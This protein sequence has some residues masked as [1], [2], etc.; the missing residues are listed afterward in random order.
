MGLEIEEVPLRASVSPVRP[1]LEALRGSVESI[2]CCK[3]YECR[4]TFGFL[5]EI[6]GL[7]AILSSVRGHHVRTNE[8]AG[9][10]PP[11]LLAPCY[12]LLSKSGSD[13]VLQLPKTNIDRM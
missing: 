10:W 3:S 9:T 2:S 13:T 4:K 8:N 5:F 1:T 12:L 11:F 7:P 6:S